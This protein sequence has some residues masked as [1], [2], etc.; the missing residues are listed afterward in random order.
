MVGK[1]LLY[2]GVGGI[3]DLVCCA[4]GVVLRWCVGGSDVRELVG[5]NKSRGITLDSGVAHSFSG[6]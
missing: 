4:I 3:I 5:K 2:V 1:W 6:L